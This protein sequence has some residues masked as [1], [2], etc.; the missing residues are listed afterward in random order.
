[1]LAGQVSGG[2]QTIHAPFPRRSF[3]A[4]VSGLAPW[5]AAWEELRA[6]GFDPAEQR[7]AWPVAVFQASVHVVRRHR[8]G[9]LPE[10][11]GMRQLG[12]AWAEGLA[13]TPVGEVVVASLAGATPEQ[14]MRRLALHVKVARQD[15]EIQVEG[16]AERAWRLR[17]MQ[18]EPLPEFNRGA[19]EALLARAGNGMRV[20]V[21][22]ETRPE[23]PPSLLVRW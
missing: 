20:T 17:L 13:A 16:V 10:A 19:F 22:L 18:A 8:F 5:C 11:E 23:Q 12:H 7:D 9:A 21:E 14:A 2:D 15:A 4:L 6:V 1:M 3:E